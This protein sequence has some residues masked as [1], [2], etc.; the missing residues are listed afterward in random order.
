MNDLGRRL[1]A[2]ALGTGILV[3]T[4]VGS[5]IMAE[6]L[7]G[8][9]VALALLGN[10]IP[11]G[12]IL[13]VLITILGPV[14]GAHFNPVVTAAMAWLG[15]FPKREILPYIATQVAGGIS[16]AFLAHA[17]FVMPLLQ[18]ST[19]LRWGQG[20]WIAEAV[21]SFG[22]LMTIMGGSRYASNAIPTL[23]GLYITAAYWFTASTSFANPAVTIAR[24]MSDSFAGISPQS[25]L[26]FIAAQCVGAFAAA[27]VGN[28]LFR[29]S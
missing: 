20:Q 6:K 1:T 28:W 9:N 26:P 3:T 16:G 29:E 7:S 15:K 18:I 19:K 27:S 17:M 23:V 10:T 22:L 13:V 2:E 25:V 24:S 11:T 4:V 5:G 21:A 12:A 8:G 14:S